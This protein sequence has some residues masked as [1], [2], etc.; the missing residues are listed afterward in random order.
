MYSTNKLLIFLTSFILLLCNI[1]VQETHAQCQ[2]QITSITPTGTA[3]P[4]EPLTFIG[5]GQGVATAFD[6]N[7]ST[8]PTGWVASAFTLGQPCFNP[9]P[10]GTNYFWSAAGESNIPR[11][12]QTNAIDATTGGNLIFE[13]DFGKDDPQPGCEEVDANEGVFLQYSIDGGTNWVDIQYFDPIDPS[14]GA[15]GYEW[16]LQNIPIPSAA[17]TV[18]TMFRW[19]Q[20]NHS[21]TGYDNWGLDNISVNQIVPVIAH[22]WDFGDG[23]PLDTSGGTVSHAYTA[24]GIYTVTYTATVVGGCTNSVTTTVTVANPIT[25]IADVTV[26]TTSGCTASLGSVSLGTPTP[27]SACTIVGSTSDAPDPLPI[28]PTVV[29]WTSTFSN[30]YTTTTTHTVTVVDLEPPVV[31]VPLDISVNADAGECT[32]T[33][34]LSSIPNG[35]AT[36]NCGIASYLYTLSGAT[37]G[38]TTTLLDEVFNVGVTTVTLTVTDASGN[39]ASNT[40]TITVTETEPPAITVP[41][42]ITVNTDAGICGAVV[43]YTTSVSDNCSSFSSG[44]SSLSTIFAAGNGS[45]GNMFD[46]VTNTNSVTINSFEQ[47][48]QSVGSVTMRVYYKVGTYVGS[49]TNTAVWTLLGTATVVSTFNGDIVS[50]PIGGLTIPANSTYGLYVTT[51]SSTVN[52]TN[53]TNSYSDTNITINTGVGKTY[54][55]GDTYTPRTWNGT[56]NYSVGGSLILNQT[57]GLASGS[58]FP[59][60]TT[61]NTF[62]AT[63][64]AGNT[65]TESFTVT[66]TDN[67]IPVLTA[68]TDF[69][70]NVNTTNCTFINPITAEN[71]PNGIASD[72][73]SIASYSYVLTG[74]TTGI[75][76]TLVNQVFNLGTTTVTWTATD[77][78][79][80]IST[81][82]EFIV[83]ISDNQLPALTAQADFTRNTDIGTCSFVNIDI[84]DG[85]A[86]DNCSIAS[87]QYVLTGATTGTVTTLVNQIFNVGVTTVTWTATDASGNISVSDEFTVTVRE[88]QIPTL[89][90][91]ADF[92]RNVDAAVCTFTNTDI[93]NGVAT[94]DCTIASYSYVFTGATTGTVT[95][96]TNQVFN[97]GVTTVTWTATD[98]SGNISVNDVFTITVNDAQNPLLTAQA[99]FTRN[100]DNGTC[101]FVNIDI[102]NGV[103]SDNCAVASY[104]YVLAGATTGTVT[105]LVNQVF[106]VGTT[107]ITWTATDINGNVSLSDEFTVIVLDNQLPIVT[108]PADIVV[109]NTGSCSSIVTYSLPTATD[110]C[111]IASIVQTAG[112]P[113]GSSFPANTTTNTFQITD[114]NGNSTTCS[115]DVTVNQVYDLIYSGTIFREDSYATNSGRIENVIT[116]ES[117]SCDIFAGLVGEDYV[118]T[119]KVN[120]SNVPNGLTASIIK[121]SDTE[122]RFSL[123]GAANPNTRAES[124]N[125]LS[126]AFNDNAFNGVVATDVNN[127]VRTDLQVIFENHL[128]INL[129]STG[130]ST[131]QIRLYWNEDTG[132]E[133]FRLYR[134]ITRIADLPGNATYYIDEN[135]DADTFYQYHIFGLV[136]G[137][138]MEI[139]RTNNWTYPLAPTFI[140]LSNICESGQ[141]QLTLTSSAFFYNVYADSISQTALMMSDGNDAFL[142]PF[143]S[144]TTTFYV[145][146]IGQ[147]PLIL[148]ESTRIPVRVEPEIG[149]DASIEGESIQLSC[150]NSI[151][152]IAR[153]VQGATYTWFLNGRSLGRTGRNIIVENSGNYQVKIQRSSCAFTSE[154]V[155]VKLNQT[156]IAQIEQPNGVKFCNEGVLSASNIS[157]ES[158]YQ[159]LLN[160]IVVGEGTNV[161]VSQSGIYTLKVTKNDCQVSA[162]VEVVISSSPQLPILTAT[163]NAICPNTE[164]TISVQNVENGVVYQWFRNGRNIGQ[165]GNS[166]TTSI[167]GDYQVYSQNNV[168]SI[169]SEK[170]KVIRFGVLPIYLRVSQ[171]KKSLFL[172]DANGSQSNIASVEWYLNGELDA[173]LGTNS[174]VIPSENGHYSA[175]ITNQNGCIT[176]TRIAYFA[177]PVVTGEETEESSLFKIYPNPSTGLFNIHFGTV[178]LEDIQITVFDGIGRIIYSTT[179]QKGSQDFN[180]N[181]KNN[182]S[183]MYMI[184]FNQN[185]STYTK[186]II[187]N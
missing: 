165:I 123:Q 163:E 166:L 77:I 73:C 132:Y 176:E 92:I 99:D 83:T 126:V 94:D 10:D 12:V 172:E 160:D 18:S 11:F 61:T 164:T 62:T 173:S 38:T 174:E 162:Q 32:F 7:G 186:Q 48:I 131:S 84:P 43:S 74:A 72:N 185:K 97:V 101:S 5:T 6:F 64:A 3:C 25:A 37:T 146:V 111:G 69:A 22:S 110:N 53:G 130:L 145:S 90:A 96:L 42:D 179:F 26:P 102:P 155:V 122:L 20:P 17:Q 183:G 79:G 67:Q 23:S 140:S 177:L 113:S 106:N 15:I 31:T 45:N 85:V 152:L 54:P 171:D 129:R 104:Q 82:D 184:H 51:T 128:P 144:Q 148:K 44:S 80:N 87:Y 138:E 63:D 95:T 175:K 108:C 28:G 158:N 89:T 88:T 134:G 91:Q 116:I 119:G 19:I 169:V 127:S 115:F 109:S 150:E 33:N 178:L 60:G 55:F 21:G 70:R 118:T 161:S 56:I 50:V 9:A 39:F 4:N 153:E 16:I 121:I 133:A 13:M 71:I 76:T 57:A 93:P 8:F 159:W 14:G 139:S 105:T 103:A 68:Q 40:F 36:D 58:T 81:S 142:L 149:F 2:A 170:L 156:P 151:E 112:L 143:I 1:A 167:Q 35:T 49:T 75:V 66:V 137:T 114:V 100:T 141:A 136:N 125:D 29:T 117:Y 59:V 124:I 168:C 135:L 24:T 86:S 98:V 65:A 157:S 47:N 187:I 27:T 30:G 52:Y 182:S 34:V 107:T 41:T 180:L 181:L 46:V 78:Y 120:V 154:K 147:D